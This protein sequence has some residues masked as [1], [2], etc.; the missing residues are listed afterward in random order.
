MGELWAIG[1]GMEGGFAGGH[2]P[3]PKV[4]ATYDRAAFTESVSGEPPYEPAG[5]STGKLVTNSQGGSIVHWAHVSI[6]A[7]YGQVAG[8]H[9]TITPHIDQY[10]SLGTLQ[11][12][13]VSISVC[14]APL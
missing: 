2:N 14:C 6:R 10:P 9:S 1:E 7:I 3:T 8:G 12:G 13:K 5:R 11:C 4:P